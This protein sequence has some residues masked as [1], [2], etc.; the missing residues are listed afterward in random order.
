[1]GID[2]NGGGVQAPA[3][4]PVPATRGKETESETET[5]SSSEAAEN[6]SASNF[7][8]SGKRTAVRLDSMKVMKP[9]QG[10]ICEAE[11]ANET[12]GPLIR[13]SLKPKGMTDATYKGCSSLYE[14][15]ERSCSKYPNNPLLGERLKNEDGSVSDYKWMTYR[16]VKE[17]V[18]ALGSGLLSEGLSPQECI[19]VFVS[20]QKLG[21][22]LKSKD[23][24]ATVKLIVYWG[25]VSSE[26][27]KVL[28]GMK[29][30]TVAFLDLLSSGGKRLP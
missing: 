22:L 16:E 9:E 18:V 19:A 6:I 13:S 3:P 14:I 4:A 7:R 12:Q 20:G 23:N 24:M 10:W 17:K 2:R 1:M 5:M 27:K 15:F 29:I 26:N 8:Y 28:S 25:D 21:N 30:K 11:P